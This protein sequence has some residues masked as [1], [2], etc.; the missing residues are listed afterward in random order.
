MKWLYGNVSSGTQTFYNGNN[1]NKV[2]KNEVNNKGNK[3]VY[4]KYDVVD[5]G[6]MVTL[7]DGNGKNISRVSLAKRAKH[8]A[9]R[10]TVAPNSTSRKKGLISK[11][12]AVLS[13]C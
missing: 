12:M 7:W 8:A 13:I 4:C 11:L 3:K 9:A 1:F 6:W 5:V 10:E 2:I